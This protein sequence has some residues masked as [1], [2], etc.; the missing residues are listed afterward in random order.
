[1]HAR[2]HE[3]EPSHTYSLPYR[4]RAAI[5]WDLPPTWLE[6]ASV[7]SWWDLGAWRGAS[8]WLRER[9]RDGGLGRLGE[10]AGILEWVS[11]PGF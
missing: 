5:S 3:V 2:A 10:W 9:E 6:G 1:M 8:V 4:C 11:N 7:L